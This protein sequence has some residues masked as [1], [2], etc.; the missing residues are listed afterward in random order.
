MVTFCH[1]FP[2]SG[3]YLFYPYGGGLV[4]KSDIYVFSSHIVP[5]T[6]GNVKANFSENNA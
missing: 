2:Q 5:K 4:A 6:A 3:M 1:P